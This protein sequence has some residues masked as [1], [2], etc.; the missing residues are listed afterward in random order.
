MFQVEIGWRA[1]LALPSLPLQD[2][3]HLPAASKESKQKAKFEVE[4]GEEL[5]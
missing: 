2:L 5:D 4:L 3:R 1:R